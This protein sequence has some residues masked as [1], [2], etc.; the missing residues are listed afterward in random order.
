MDENRIIR[1]RLSSPARAGHQL[2]TIAN[3]GAMP[4]SN[5]NYFAAYPSSLPGAETEGG[6]DTATIDGT[7]PIYVIGVGPKVPQVGE[8][9][10]AKECGGRWAVQGSIA[11]KIAT[12]GGCCCPALPKVLTL[13]CFGYTPTFDSLLVGNPFSSAFTTTFTHGPPPGSGRAW[14]FAGGAP[15][16][17]FYG[18]LPN[19]SWYSD[20]GAY[21]L[22]VV[23]NVVWI[24]PLGSISVS[25]GNSG[26]PFNLPEVLIG[27]DGQPLTSMNPDVCP[28]ANMIATGDLAIFALGWG[29]ASLCYAGFPPYHDNAAACNPLSLTEWSTEQDSFSG[30]GAITR[31]EYFWTSMELGGEPYFGMVNLDSTCSA[32]A[33][34]GMNKACL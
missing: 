32:G 26:P 1:N 18:A 11:G 23:N 24:Y 31:F 12:P 6:A 3:L 29:Q 19:P 16:N 22:Y 20:D 4:F 21:M 5:N 9:L 33:F 34:G 25:T 7:A 2:V 10:V 30:S 27:V 15:C 13:T 8:V 14:D 17:S 28:C